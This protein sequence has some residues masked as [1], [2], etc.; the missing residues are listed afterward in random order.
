MRRSSS[1]FKQNHI[2]IKVEDSSSDKVV[3]VEGEIDGI[4]IWHWKFSGFT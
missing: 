4:N 1:I 3:L 2:F